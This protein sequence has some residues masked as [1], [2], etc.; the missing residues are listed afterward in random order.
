[1]NK[2]SDIEAFIK[3]AKSD[4]SIQGQLAE[5]QLDKWGESHTPL[6]VDLKKVIQVAKET[7]FTITEEDL[8]HAQCMQL[9]QFWTFEMA[10]SI[11]ARRSLER[12]QM[13]ISGARASMNH[14]GYY[15]NLYKLVAWINQDKKCLGINS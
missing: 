4:A 12:I 2:P 8:I 15:W 10:N 7:G 9:D 5:C 13:Q 3:K 11:V 1:M 6:D 14:Y